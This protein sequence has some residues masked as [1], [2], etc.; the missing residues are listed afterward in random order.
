MAKKIKDKEKELETK[1]SNDYVGLGEKISNNKKWY[2]GAIALAVV[3]TAIVVVVLI[4]TKS[5]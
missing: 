1:A 2:Y 3:I 5:L 4:V